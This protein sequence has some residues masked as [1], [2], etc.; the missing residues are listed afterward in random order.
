[1]AKLIHSEQHSSLK[2]KKKYLL[3]RWRVSR[4]FRYFCSAVTDSSASLSSAILTFIGSKCSANSPM[5]TQFR[6]YTSINGN[7]V[8]EFTY[9]NCLKRGYRFWQDHA[10]W[11]YDQHGCRKKQSQ[12]WSMGYENRIYTFHFVGL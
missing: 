12:V 5:K 10:Q 6:T 11:E 8:A 1:M 4:A 3:W 2:R 9:K 7:I